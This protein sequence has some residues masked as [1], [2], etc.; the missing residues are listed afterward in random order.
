[1]SYVYDQQVQEKL[2]SA[3]YDALMFAV[4]TNVINK[5]VMGDLARGLGQR[6][7]GGHLRRMEDRGRCDRREL[8][9]VLSDWY[10]QGSMFQ[11]S[12]EEALDQ[13]NTIFRSLD[14]IIQHDPQTTESNI[15]TEM[16]N[17][18]MSVPDP[19][20]NN[21]FS[22][23]S[24][25]TIPINSP[26][27][28]DTIGVPSSSSRKRLAFLVAS[29]YQQTAELRSLP[30]TVRSAEMVREAIAR[31]GFQSTL[32]IDRP[33]EEIREALVHWKGKAL[34]GEE[35]DALLLYFCGHG[36]NRHFVIRVTDI[37]FVGHRPFE[38]AAVEEFDDTFVFD[39]PSG[40]IGVGGD[41][42]FDNQNSTMFKN[43]VMQI[44]CEVKQSSND[45]G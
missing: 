20:P 3:A 42:L 33:F 23:F 12:R 30:G 45:L 44:L 21:M 34:D 32:H 39:G 36:G 28:T 37:I 27:C 31:H 10:N 9:Q 1:M 13:L 24:S 35:P 17:P 7:G 4:E 43:K 29:T 2:G 40:S 6:I 5:A 15:S 18:F 41:V 38:T 26:V 11:L 22:Q 14:V 19:R 8:K 25:N 16:A